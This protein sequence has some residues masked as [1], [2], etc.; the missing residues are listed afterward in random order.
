M[1]SPFVQAVIYLGLFSDRYSYNE[2]GKLKPN[3]NDKIF[4]CD[5][6]AILVM[7][8]HDELEVTSKTP[9]T[10][11]IQLY[12]ENRSSTKTVF[13]KLRETYDPH[14]RPIE[15][16]IRYTINKF[17]TP[18]SLSDNTRPNKPHPARSEKNMAAVVRSVRDDHDESIRR[19]SQQ[20][21]LSYT[22]PI[23][24]KAY[25]IQ[26]V[27][28]MKPTDLPSRHRFSVWALEMFEENPLFSIKI[29]FSDEAHFWQNWD[30]EQFEEIQEL[31]LHPEKTTDWCGLWAG[32]IIGP[33]FFKNEDRPY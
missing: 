33:Y 19:R 15:R 10:K 21:G 31:P 29:V 17:E 13:R 7:K 11:I 8:H 18:Y 6:C 2:L 30:E 23:G 4:T 24:L 9:G 20:L 16:T 22:R 26:L 5:Y 14:N 25:K 3:S 1:S 12:Y 27:Q 32:G 28:D